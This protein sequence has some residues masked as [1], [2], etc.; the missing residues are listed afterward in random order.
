MDRLARPSFV[1][2][3]VAFAAGCPS[4][5]FGA[6]PEIR[7]LT[8]GGEGRDTVTISFELKDEDLSTASVRVEYTT[9][10]DWSPATLTGTTLGELSAGAVTGLRLGDEWTIC[11]LEWDTLSDSVG[12]TGPVT[13]TLRLTP[14]DS[15]GEGD[16]VEIT[17]TVS[18]WH[19]RL[20]ATESELALEALTGGPNPGEL[21]FLESRVPSGGIPLGKCSHS[22][23]RTPGRTSAGEHVR[24][25]EHGRNGVQRAA[26]RD[27]PRAWMAGID[28][29]RIGHGEVPHVART[30][31]GYHSEGEAARAGA[32]DQRNPTR[33]GAAKAR[34][35]GCVWC[36]LRPEPR[37]V[38]P[39]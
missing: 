36:A 12:V 5:P 15:D 16:P 21:A 25:H 3:V 38:L 24:L 39:G 19:P 2:F 22:S 17:V 9:G 30:A 26:Q 23:R 1:I 10:G 31:G 14:L 13:V 7:G 33:A 8:E 29:H 6:R 4:G 37:A 34:T 35:H 11:E 18:N 28:G 27:R 32:Q 20:A